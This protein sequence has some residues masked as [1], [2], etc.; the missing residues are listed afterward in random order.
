M[1]EEPV[2]EEPD[3]RGAVE[4]PEIRRDSADEGASGNLIEN[5]GFDGLKGWKSAQSRARGEFSLRTEDG[6]VLWKRTGS[7]GGGANFGVLQPLDVDVTE[8]EKVALELDVRVDSHTLKGTGWWSEQ[9]GGPGETPVHIC[10]SYKDAAGKS[11]AW[12]WGFIVHQGSRKTS[13]RNCTTVKG[14]AWHHGSFDLLDDRVRQ[15][16][17]G[18]FVL[19]RPARITRVY[20][21]GSGWDFEGGVRNLSLRVSKPQGNSSPARPQENHE[22]SLK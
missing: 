12:H 21:Y 15:E 6:A 10:V 18:K 17:Q 11:H 16:A 14:G 2:P 7:R 13:V 4:T 1:T 20:V 9:R 22:E 19:P 8:A 3:E 5:G